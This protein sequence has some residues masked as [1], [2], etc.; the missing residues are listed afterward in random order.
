ML[1]GQ[2]IVMGGSLNWALVDGFPGNPSTIDLII[3]HKMINN[4]NRD[5]F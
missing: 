1:L 3:A 5:I 4:D 2:E